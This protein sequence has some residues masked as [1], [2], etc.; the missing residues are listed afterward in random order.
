MF[1]LHE[2]LA[3]D[4]MIVGEFPLSLVLLMNDSQYP[5]LILVPKRAEL[6]E[7]H[8]LSEEDQRQLMK[9]SVFVSKAMK[10]FFAA[11]KMNVAAL[12]NMVSQLHVHHVA[13]F[14][15]DIAWPKPVWGVASSV[16]YAEEQKESVLM[17]YK[18][19]LKEMLLEA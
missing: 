3:Q 4:T 17:Q 15:H 14:E 1:Q 7:M 19:L 13:R 6:T 8:E 9:E 12:G 16:V 18:N 10:K 2:R 5:W 11:K